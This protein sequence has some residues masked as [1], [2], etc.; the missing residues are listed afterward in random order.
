MLCS[1]LT[2]KESLINSESF[3]CEVIIPERRTVQIKAAIAANSHSISKIGN[4]ELAHYNGQM[5]VHELIRDSLS[6]N[7]H[8]N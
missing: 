5:L 8:I 7:F 6:R 4:D 3:S 2:I 1:E